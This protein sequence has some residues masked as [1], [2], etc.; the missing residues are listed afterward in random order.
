[1][2]PFNLTKD[3]VWQREGVMPNA[4]NVTTPQFTKKDLEKLHFPELEREHVLQKWVIEAEIPPDRSNRYIR[5]GK[6]GG[7]GERALQAYLCVLQ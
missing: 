5:A 7:F 2:L 1:L 3:A 4:A 6:R